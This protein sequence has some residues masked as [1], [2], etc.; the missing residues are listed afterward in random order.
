MDYSSP[1][2]H[3]L[4]TARTTRLAAV[5]VVALGFM[6]CTGSGSV[7][8]SAPERDHLTDA[9]MV[10][11]MDHTVEIADTRLRVGVRHDDNWY[12]IGVLSTQ[13]ATVQQIAARGLTV[14]FDPSGEK[15]RGLGIRYPVG[16]LNASS[17]GPTSEADMPRETEERMDLLRESAPL[18]DLYFE[19]GK[20][21]R[22]QLAS[23]PGLEAAY[24]FEF[25]AFTMELRIPRSAAQSDDF[26][27]PTPSE[28]MLR[29]GFATEQAP[30]PPD[31]DPGSTLPGARGNTGG[32][33]AVGR[34]FGGRGNGPSPIFQ[35][36]IDE[37]IKVVLE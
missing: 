36:P 5:G 9:D 18:V 14:W 37:W 28:G 19:E 1:R 16:I 23:L 31:D 15:T 2:W 10:E 33:G 22:R 17:G 8:S 7:T 12:Y 34:D 13:R 11:W 26:S 32:F 3:R 21:I 29:V 27:V 25:G 24:S 4:L 20:P 35:G 6:G 30:R